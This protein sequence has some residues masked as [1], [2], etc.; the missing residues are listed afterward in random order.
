MEPI[1]NNLF[2]SGGL[3]INDLPIKTRA[4]R[5][6]DYSPA[7]ALSEEK[8]KLVTENWKDSGGSRRGSGVQTNPLLS[9][10]YF[11]ILRNFRKNGSTC[12]NRTPPRLIW[13]PDPKILDPPLKDRE[14]KI[15]KDYTK[16]TCTSSFHAGNICKVS[17][18]LVDNCKGSCA[19]KVP[20][21]YTLW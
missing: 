19:Y 11:I 9:Q 14:K 8:G 18:Q 17:N 12:K 15:P 16:T 21:V 13:T 3:G 5:G 1:L 20:I 4:V 6:S 2:K 10:N 7:T